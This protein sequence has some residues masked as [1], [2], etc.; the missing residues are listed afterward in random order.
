M[1]PR[2]VCLVLITTIYG[3]SGG[4]P[5]LTPPDLR[6]ASAADQAIALYDRDGSGDLSVDE[7]QACP[8]MLSALKTYDLDGDGNISMDE[9]TARLELF[10][11][12]RVALTQL[13]AVVRLGNRPLAG[14]TILFVPEPYLGSAIKSA[15]GKT[16]RSGGAMMDVDDSELPSN[17]AGL[18]GVQLAT[19]RVEITHPEIT[20]PAKYN[21]NTTLGYD[22]QPGKPSVIFNLETR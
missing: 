17:Q 19:Y 12:S 10:A 9:I 7:L 15:T 13:V 22:S 18:V 8:G 20:I 16:G 5:A 1:L 11:K 6:P 3:C 2:V 4:P 14:A 21:T